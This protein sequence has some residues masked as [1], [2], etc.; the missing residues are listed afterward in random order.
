MLESIISTA[1]KTPTASMTHKSEEEDTTLSM[2]LDALPNQPPNEAP[3]DA[4]DVWRYWYVRACV[5][6]DYYQLMRRLILQVRNLWSKWDGTASCAKLGFSARSISHA[7][8]HT[9]TRS[10]I[11]N[12]DNVVNVLCGRGASITS[13]Y[14]RGT[15]VFS[16]AHR[17]AQVISYVRTA[18][19]DRTYGRYQ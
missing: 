8:I 2:F 19:L 3:A 10:L 12:C 18:M 7:I 5:H 17:I 4:L 9:G 14:V 15:R 6:H 16:L 1:A 11:H 13:L